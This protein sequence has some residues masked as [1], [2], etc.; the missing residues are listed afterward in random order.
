MAKE[1]IVFFYSDHTSKRRVAVC[2]IINAENNSINYGISICNPKDTFI[3]QHARKIAHGRALKNP[4]EVETLTGESP[5]GKSFH[6]KAAAIS[7][8]VLSQ[9]N[10]KKK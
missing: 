6:L 1:R 5:S 3:K 2:G 8:A 10:K 4:I 7:A 9:Y